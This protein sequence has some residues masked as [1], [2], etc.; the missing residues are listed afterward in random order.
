[1]ETQVLHLVESLGLGGMEKVVESLVRIQK[2][3]ARALCI[4]VGGEVAESMRREGLP[5]DILDH[6][7]GGGWA[8]LPALAHRMRASRPFLLHTHGAARAGDGRSS[9]GR[10]PD[11]LF[12]RR[13]TRGTASSELRSATVPP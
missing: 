12:S 11:L 13:S 7:L 5:V 10:P 2:P 6:P 1:M 9:V 4:R 8:S 3:N